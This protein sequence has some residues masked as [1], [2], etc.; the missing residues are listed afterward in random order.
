ME[1]E[2]CRGGVGCRKGGEPGK[3]TPSL[4]YGDSFLTKNES[5][6]NCCCSRYPMLCDY[7]SF[8][9]DMTYSLVT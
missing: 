4:E 8:M 1:G 3:G 2:G 9:C 7:D 5:I 6:A